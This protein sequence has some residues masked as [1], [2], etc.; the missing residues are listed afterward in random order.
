VED[1]STIAASEL[2]RRCWQEG[3]PLLWEE[4]VK[5]FHPTVAAVAMRRAR[6]WGETRSDVVADLIQEIFLKLSSNQGRLLREFE[7]Q[8]PDAFFGY[9]KVVT[10]NFVNDYFKAT[11]ADKR[12]KGVEL[13]PLNEV[14]HRASASLGRGLSATELKLLCD[15]MDSL[16]RKL[17]PEETAERDRTIFWLYYRT[18]LTAGAIAGLPSISM[19]P[20]SVE[21]VI[22]RLT[23]LLRT[24]LVSTGPGDS[25][26]GIGDKTSL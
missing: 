8:H 24:E 11:L 22:H 19:N 5:R 18:G 12:G 26:K 3:T 15:E 2:V 1:H 4:F 6:V 13:L 21:S 23:H 16:L 7:P 25:P 9:L 20:K 17:L 10:V 14:E